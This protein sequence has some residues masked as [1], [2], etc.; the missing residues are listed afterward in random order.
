M[1]QTEQLSFLNIWTY[2]GPLIGVIFGAILGFLGK[3]IIEKRREK[4]QKEEKIQFV[5]CVELVNTKVFGKEM[6]GPIANKVQIKARETDSTS[7]LIEVNEIYFVRYRIRNLSDSPLSNL[8]LESG[9]KP[10]SI[11]FSLKEGVNQSS[12]E[13]KKQ[14]REL[15]KKQKA[16]DVRG[17]E[18]Y[19][20]PYLNP[21]SSTKHEV[22]LDLSSYLPLTD[23]RITGGGKGINFI[24]KKLEDN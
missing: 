22:F 6:L 14:F 4:F 16:S 17:Y 2:A 10:K 24:F 15:L 13:W 23:V 19:P 18:A 8:L 7:E 20:I 11:T 21:Y 12:P 3:L 5:E 9:N 1:N